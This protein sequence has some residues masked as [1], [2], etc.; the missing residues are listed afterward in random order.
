METP[1]RETQLDPFASEVINDNVFLIINGK[2]EG[3]AAAT[4]TNYGIFFVADRAWKVISISERHRTAG[5]SNGTVTVEK[6]GSGVAPDSGV[7]LLSSTIS[8]TTTAN[9]PQ[10]GTMSNNRNDL[11]IKKNDSLILKDGGTLTDVADVCVT[12][13]L[14]RA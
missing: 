1:F 13:L 11:I 7:D 14:K 4:A 2:V 9:I 12:V 8:L 5:S 3:A 6:C 10:F